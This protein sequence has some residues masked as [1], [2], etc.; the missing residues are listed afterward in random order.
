[1]KQGIV[2]EKAKSRR[3][4]ERL[5]AINAELMEAAEALLIECTY[6][7]DYWGVQHRAKFEFGQPVN[8]C[9]K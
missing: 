2:D 1:M 5:K 7:D 6:S 8:P 4:I 3:E 9:P